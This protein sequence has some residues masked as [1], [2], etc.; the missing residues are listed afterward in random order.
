MCPCYIGAAA[1]GKGYVYLPVFK[2]L[3]VTIT[4]WHMLE[5]IKAGAVFLREWQKPKD[6]KRIVRIKP[7]TA[8]NILSI[9]RHHR[10]S[11]ATLDD[12]GLW[13]LDYLVAV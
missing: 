4:P 3:C 12:C 1:A 6:T 11:Y 8:L 9:I 2:C 10:L 5:V 7:P 13:H